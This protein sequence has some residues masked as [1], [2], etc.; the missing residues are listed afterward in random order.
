M[1]VNLF[2]DKLGPR[3]I[4]S[5]IETLISVAKYFNHLKII[6]KLENDTSMLANCTCSIVSIFSESKFDEE[7][8]QSIIGVSL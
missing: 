5:M 6:N 3:I 4:I 1:I 7:R 2:L 8:F